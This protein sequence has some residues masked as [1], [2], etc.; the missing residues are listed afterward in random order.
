MV[1]LALYCLEQAK[2]KRILRALATVSCR[3]PGI[4]TNWQAA[5][6]NTRDSMPVQEELLQYNLKARGAGLWKERTR[7]SN[8]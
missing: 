5:L 4:A 3:S 7:Q 1:R 8:Y 6:P 2:A